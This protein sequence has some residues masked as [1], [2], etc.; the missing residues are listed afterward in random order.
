V[1]LQISS[2]F[3]LPIEAVTQTFGILAKRGVGKTYTA[4]VMAEAMLEAGQVVCIVDPIGVWWGLRASADGKR[5]GQPIIVFGG[6][7]GDLPLEAGAGELIADV[8]VEKRVSVVLDLSHLRKGEMHRFMEAFAERLYHRNREPLHLFLDEADAWAPQNPL[9]GTQRLLGAIEDLVRRGRARGIGCTLITQRAAVLNKSVLTQIEVLVA[10]RTVGPQDRKAIDDWI[11]VHGSPAQRK[12]L[13]DSL[14]SLPVGTAWFWSPGWLDVFQR[15]E[16]R[17]RKTFDSSATPKPGVKVT[18]PERLAAV[19]IEALRGSIGELVEKAKADD[20]RTLKARIAELER[21]IAAKP[22]APAVDV[23]ARALAQARE[24]GRNDVRLAQRPASAFL[25]ELRDAV[26]TLE[27]LISKVNAALAAGGYV[28]MGEAT[29]DSQAVATSRRDVAHAVTEIRRGMPPAAAEWGRKFEALAESNSLP[30]LRVA[31]TS[32]PSNST[33]VKLAG[34]ERKVLTALA[35]YP[36]GRSKRQVAILTGYAGNGGGF[37]NAISAAR[38]AGRL[39]GS[40]ES[41]RITQKGLSD[42]G[43]YT[44]LP[45]GKAL[46][47]YWMGQ[48]DKAQRAILGALEAHGPLSKENVAAAAGYEANGGGF[49][50]ALSRLRTLE[51]I[52]GGGGGDISLSEELEG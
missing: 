29:W 11:N 40:G 37:N 47:A 52:R 31:P 6:D 15:V 20:P 17:A 45:T 28:L 48:L 25:D 51:L 49:N 26:R 41:L 23:E 4:A 21:A 3:A 10:L 30:A 36:R 7:H 42:L 18:A 50:N 1:K 46:L 13:M 9:P 35:Q 22:A 38:S 24:V 43:H 16:V 32:P 33:G 44:P 8:V 14:A 19:D 12:E 5:E 39:E 2:K 27:P 34:A